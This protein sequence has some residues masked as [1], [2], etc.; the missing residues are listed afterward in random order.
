M[1]EEDGAG[2]GG[3]AVHGECGFQTTAPNSS[4]ISASLLVWDP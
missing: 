1:G 4:P 2:A 3:W